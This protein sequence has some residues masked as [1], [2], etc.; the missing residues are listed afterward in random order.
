MK[1]IEKRGKALKSLEGTLTADGDTAG[2]ERVKD[3]L[4]KLRNQYKFQQQEI[5]R[6]EN[7]LEAVKHCV[8]NSHWIDF[9]CED[10][11]NLSS[12]S[13]CLKIK[14]KSYLNLSDDMQKSKIKE[15]NTILEKENVAYDINSYRTAPPGFRIWGGSTVETSDI[16][17]LLP[18]LDWAYTVVNG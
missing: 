12:T 14:D 9:L 2:A 11:D 3:K 6:S 5:K 16:E 18:W 1:D 7:N 8:K 17:N 10:Y 4:Q 15:I 13:I